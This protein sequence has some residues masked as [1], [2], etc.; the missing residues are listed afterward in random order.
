MRGHP[1][2]WRDVYA[3]FRCPG[4]PCDLG[5]YCWRDP[6]S[7][8][9]YKLRTSH[10]KTCIDFLEQGK[11]LQSHGDVPEYIRKQLVAEEQQ[12]LNRQPNAPANAA[13]PTSIY[14]HYKYSP[15][16]PSVIYCWFSGNP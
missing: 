14:Q 4:P 15:V 10:V 9:R 2:V 7:R 16:F 11:T 6:I 5:P 12:R 8:K 3:L 13:T 1:S